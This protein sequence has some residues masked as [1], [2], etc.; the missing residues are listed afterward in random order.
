MIDILGWG[1]LSAVDV[2]QNIMI[3]VLFVL[4]AI[5]VF[6]KEDKK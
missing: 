1:G 3:V 4:I 5:L 2:G 6:G